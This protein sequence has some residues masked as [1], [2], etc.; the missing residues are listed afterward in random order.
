MF[1]FECCFQALV[2]A[3]HDPE[4]Y[5]FGTEETKENVPEDSLNETDDVMNENELVVKDD[6]DDQPTETSDNVKEEEKEPAAAQSEHMDNEDSLNLSI[7]ED[8]A[9][10]LQV[11]VCIHRWCSATYMAAVL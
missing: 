7:G 6:I 4:T 5:L 11:E 2:Q 8:E 1:A 9:N 3:G 10:L